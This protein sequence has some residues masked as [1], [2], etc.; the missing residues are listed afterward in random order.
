MLE[1]AVLN[2]HRPLRLL[3]P[4]LAEPSSGTDY[5]QLQQKK[6]PGL[7]DARLLWPARTT[8]QWQPGW[9]GGWL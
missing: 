9:W 5:R 1:M 6:S 4:E 8:R 2:R 3:W 7:T